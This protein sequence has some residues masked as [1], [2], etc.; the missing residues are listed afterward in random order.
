MSDFA[1]AIANMNAPVVR[2]TK[3]SPTQVTS[4]MNAQQGEMKAQLTR[5]NLMTSA[6][7]NQRQVQR[8]PEADGVL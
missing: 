5:S 3:F 4:I 2:F 6:T 7:M 1:N 8:N